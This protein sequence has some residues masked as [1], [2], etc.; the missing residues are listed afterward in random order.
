MQQLA[1]PS[2]LPLIDNCFKERLKRLTDRG[3]LVY[4]FDW[5]FTKT[6]Q[7]MPHDPLSELVVDLAGNMNKGTR[8]LRIL[9]Q[10]GVGDVYI[11][12]ERREE[13]NTY[14]SGKRLPAKRMQP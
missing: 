8:C 5:Y 4:R 14:V 2:R 9:A 6:K 3:V 11:M 1:V 13:R 7:T 10:T 12:F